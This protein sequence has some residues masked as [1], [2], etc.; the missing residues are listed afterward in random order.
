MNQHSLTLELLHETFAVAQLDGDSEVPAWAQGGP[1]VSVTR[2]RSE[3]SIV[4]VEAS[5]PSDVKAQRGFRCL[6]VLGPLDFV[7]VG[8]LESFAHPLANAGISIFALSTF[9]TDY[10]LLAEVELEAGLSALSAAGHVVRSA[11][12]AADGG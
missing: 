4:C 5:V 6:R 11:N 7:E 8:V 10:L 2:T 9:D 12:G 1:F 3:L